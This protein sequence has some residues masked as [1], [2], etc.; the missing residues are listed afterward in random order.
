ML[1]FDMES[2]FSPPPHGPPISPPQAGAGNER[3]SSGQHLTTFTHE[4]RFWDVFLEF[5]DDALR[6]GS[7]RGQLCFVPSDRA[8]HEG[9]VRT[10]VIIIEP[11]FEEAMGRAAGF[12]QHHLAA[13]LRS[14]QKLSD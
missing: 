12:D 13:M 3:P 8:D 14:V 6:P 9:A 11:T 10:T 7:C 5:V 4:G 1:D 2:Q